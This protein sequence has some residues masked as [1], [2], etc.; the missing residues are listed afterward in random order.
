MRSAQQSGSKSGKC[1]YVDAQLGDDKGSGRSEAEAFKSLSKVN[2]LSLKAGDKVLF[3]R[4]C[5]F[6]GRLELSAN[7]LEDNRIYIDAY[8]DGDKP[9]ISAPDNSLYAIQI[10]NSN[11]ITVQNLEVV[12]RGSAPLAKR[13][14]VNVAVSNFGVSNGITVR[15]LDIR[16][17]NGSL[18]KSKGGGSGILISAEYKSTPSRFNELLIE[19]NTIRRCERNAMIWHARKE[20]PSTNVIVRRNLIE[21]VPGDGIVP[22][23]CDGAVVEYNLMRDCP[24][25]TSLKEAAAGIWPWSS[26]NTIIRFNEV[27]DHKARWDGQGFD[28]DFNCENTIIEYNYSHDNWG[29]FLLICTPKLSTSNSG[30]NNSIIRYNLSVGDGLRPVET[31]EG[32][33]SPTIH[34]TGPHNNTLV[35][36]NILHVNKKPDNQLFPIDRTLIKFDKWDEYPTN[37]TLKDNIFYVAECSRII[38]DEKA[39]NTLFDSNY[40]LGEGG[41]SQRPTDANEKMASNYYNRALEGDIEAYNSLV[42]SLTR[43]M[44]IADGQATLRYIDKQKMQQLFDDIAQESGN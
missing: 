36:K 33:F 27:S 10:L 2:T 28:S 37:T 15:A 42:M 6:V 23:G 13:T 41:F 25:L 24:P 11:Y 35:E 14:G 32:V 43:E 9:M 34:I 20:S 17:V 16:D 30:N 29:G 5:R 21:Q 8:G 40:Y 44:T 18:V 22:I 4:G 19:D 1:Y 31:R 7:G 26:D 12:N 3:K 38:G 39:K